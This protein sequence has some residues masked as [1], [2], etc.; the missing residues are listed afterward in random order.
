MLR[1]DFYE[2]QDYHGYELTFVIMCAVYKKQWVFVR[3][4]DRNTWE[5]PGGH[6]EVGE[7]PDEAAKR[8]QL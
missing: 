3:H 2:L 5:I 6:I 8:D 7:T 4:K 1:I